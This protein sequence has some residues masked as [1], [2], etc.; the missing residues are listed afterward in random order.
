MEGDVIVVETQ[1]CYCASNERL[2]QENLK[3]RGA[4]ARATQTFR[5]IIEV[6]S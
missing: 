2:T 4:V 3:L 5:E 1:T 6:G